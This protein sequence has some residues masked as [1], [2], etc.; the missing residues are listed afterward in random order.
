M[1]CFMCPETSKG[2]FPTTRRE[3][4]NSKCSKIGVDEHFTVGMGE[5]GEGLPKYRVGL[6]LSLFL[7]PA[8]QKKL[9][10]MGE[11]GAGW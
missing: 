7:S 5:F 10:C 11:G 2:P 9:E 6:F 1:A 4:F 3:C 8:L